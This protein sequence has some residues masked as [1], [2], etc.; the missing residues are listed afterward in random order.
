MPIQLTDEL[1]SAAGVLELMD[2]G[3]SLEQEYDAW[4][5]TMDDLGHDDLTQAQR[6]YTI[7]LFGAAGEG[8]PEDFKPVGIPSKVRPEAE[9]VCPTCGK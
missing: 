6:D 2:K 8:L 3:E 7:A 5:S 1:R 9:T 4:A